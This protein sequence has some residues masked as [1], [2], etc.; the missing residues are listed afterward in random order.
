MIWILKIIIK[1]IYRI[2]NNKINY[3]YMKVCMF[4]NKKTIKYL[5]IIHIDW[6]PD[7]Y[8]Q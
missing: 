3:H 1:K 6:I 8:L 2:N 5:F 7:V 4:Q